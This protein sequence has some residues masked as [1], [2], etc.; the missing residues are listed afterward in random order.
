MSTYSAGRSV[1]RLSRRASFAVFGSTLG[2][3]LLASSAPSPL[4]ALYQQHWHFNSAL[5]TVVFAVYAAA[6]LLSLLVFGR[7]SDHLGRRPVLVAALLTTIAAMVVFL[8]ATGV[9][10]L[11]LARVLQ[12]LGAGGTTA[13]A[14]SA[15]ID[16]EP[17]DSGHGTFSSTLI[18]GFAMAAGS[19]G[20]AALVQYAPQPTRLIWIILI[21]LLSSAVIGVLCTTETFRRR[22]GALRSLRPSVSVARAQRGAFFAAVPGFVAVWALSAL[23]L[24]LGPKLTATLTGNGN[25][26][27]DTIIIAVLFGA[28]SLASI[29]FR[30]VAPA[31]SAAFGLVA[32]FIGSITVVVALSTSSVAALFLGSTVAG[33]GWGPAYLGL[34]KQLIA[35]APP[36]RRAGMVA[37]VYIVAYLAVGIPSVA[38]GITT[39]AYGLRPTAVVYTAVIVVLAAIAGVGT[40]RGR[41][42]RSRAVAPHAD[43]RPSPCTE[44]AVPSIAGGSGAG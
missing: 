29:P 19:L 3:V 32:L 11:L 13:A 30:A 42:R 1:G 31:R 27:L 39:T 15:L 41:R 6:L 17:E 10:S 25:L 35:L 7:L 40:A 24:A 12:G 2:I 38:A 34:F 20:S 37:S 44:P 21:A 26:V 16:F 33:I 5:L 9:E 36:D 28:G 43:Q 22:P 8:T 18:P 4:Y 14:S 23:Y